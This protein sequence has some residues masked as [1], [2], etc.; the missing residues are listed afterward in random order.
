MSNTAQSET[1]DFQA[2][3]KQL[4]DLVIHSLYTNKDIF[5]REL[6][7]NASD[8]LDRLRFESLTN[9]DLLID[10]ETLEVR[11]D[12]DLA[13]RTLSVSDNGI[14]MTRD[15]VIANIGSIAK[16]GTAELAEKLKAAKGGEGEFSCWPQLWRCGGSASGS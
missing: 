16:S 9:P 15:E 5:L 13:A 8:A 6:V 11:I 7:S 1:H 14:G 2:E 12:T 4:L 3:T 10:G